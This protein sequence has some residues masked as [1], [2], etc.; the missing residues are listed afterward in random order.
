MKKGMMIVTSVSL[1][2]A[3]LAGPTHAAFPEL[4]KIYRF[5]G[6][7][8]KPDP[9]FFN[10]REQTVIQCTNW[11]RNAAQIQIITYDGDTGGTL[12]GPVYTL[13]LRQTITVVTSN[14]PGS[15]FGGGDRNMEMGVLLDGSMEIRAT[16]PQVHCDV[17]HVWYYFINTPSA[18]KALQ[19]VPV[20]VVHSQHV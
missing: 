17:K 3:L 10:P 19:R 5:T 18:E 4:T 1:A 20:I 11:N 6:I 12:T 15:P 16:A 8:N 13:A 2:A 9:P 14:L 7:V